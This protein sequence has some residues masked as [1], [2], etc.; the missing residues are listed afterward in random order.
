[1]ESI[2]TINYLDLIQ[3]DPKEF[4]KNQDERRNKF[5]EEKGKEALNKIMWSNKHHD[6]KASRSKDYRLQPEEL[7][8][9]KKNG[10]YFKSNGIQSFGRAYLNLYNNDMPVFITSDSMLYAIHRFYDNYL[11]NLESTELINKLKN[12]C[13]KILDSFEK[14]PPTEFNLEILKNLE[15]F[16]KIPY[17]IMNLNNELTDTVSSDFNLI[18]PLKEIQEELMNYNISDEI[19]KFEL[20]QGFKTPI[21]INF[22]KKRDKY[23]LFKKIIGLDIKNL[24]NIIRYSPKY[25]TIFNEFKIP[26]IEEPITFQFGGD[27]LF[28][29]FIKCLANNKDIEF[30]CCGVEIK[31]MGTLFKP[32]GHYTETLQ[33]KKYFMAFTW[34]SKLEI[35]LNKRRADFEDSFLL[36]TIIA[37]TCEEHLSEF[38]HFQEFIAKIIGIS[39][40]YTINEFLNVINKN[41]PSFDCLIETIDFLIKNKSEFANK[42]IAEMT[43][44]ANL[45]KFGDY[46]GQESEFSFSLIGKGTM[47]DNIVIQSMID[48][49]LKDDNGYCPERKFTSVFDLLYTL[50]DNQSINDVLQKRMEEIEIPQR[51]GYFYNNHLSK[52]RSMYSKIIFDE[53]IYGQELR[54]LRAL[55]EDIELMKNHKLYPF[56]NDSWL[57]K[58]AQTQIGHYSELRHDNVLYLEE[59]CGGR[60]ECFYPELLIEPVPTFWKE[61]LKLIEMMKIMVPKENRRDVNILN[62]FENIINKFISYLDQY[63]TNKTVDEKL[64]EELKSIIK[65]DH[66]GSGGP[67]ITGWYARLFHDSEEALEFKPEVSSMF[68]G[69]ND[70]R[71]PGG[72][73]HLGTG[74]VQTMYVLTKDPESNEDKIVLGPVYSTYEFITPYETRLNDEEW[75]EQYNKFEPLNFNN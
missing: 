63:L 65:E 28:N 22:Y 53:T 56:F 17:V 14:I 51:D 61:F 5:K 38:N 72:I 73:V 30:M 34:L 4:N 64:I 68:T 58:Q 52:I 71:G 39:D 2:S 43:K 44:E 48:G 21:Q 41:I 16:F 1:M 60:C 40:G 55:T 42:C 7:L 27:E 19:I 37:K 66:G 15:V 67:E 31:M 47:I 13:R 20:G 24:E 23:K 26:D 33:L 45:T 32:R 59:V 10:I 75:K 54:M 70:E 50:F 12:L 3:T 36:A 35:K 62:N 57:K 11:K 18:I 6:M 46:V 74:S 49:N 69:V 29:E 25:S 9:L 8:T